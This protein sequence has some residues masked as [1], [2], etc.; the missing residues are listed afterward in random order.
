M[1][2]GSSKQ[3]AFCGSGGNIMMCC[4]GTSTCALHHIGLGD[5]LTSHPLNLTGEMLIEAEKN[6]DRQMKLINL[7]QNFVRYNTVAH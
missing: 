4:A 6:H 2:P 1:A 5:K 3:A 7:Y